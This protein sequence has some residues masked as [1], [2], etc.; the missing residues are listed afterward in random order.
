MFLSLRAHKNIL[1]SFSIKNW[2]KTFET[3]GLE[4]S[5][6]WKTINH[7]HHSLKSSLANNFEVSPLSVYGFSFS[8]FIK[9]I[10]LLCLL[11]WLWEYLRAVCAEYLTS[12]IVLI[13]MKYFPFCL[14]SLF[15]ASA[16]GLH[17]RLYFILVTRTSEVIYC[18]LSFWQLHL[19]SL[20]QTRKKRKSVLA[21]KTWKRN[22]PSDD[23]Y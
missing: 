1:S 21:L 20:D 18:R 9:K 12:Q 11:Q 5:R 4:N 22:L 14:F 13:S 16:L 10:K 19:Q 7:S 3:R 8:R 15:I 6:Q 17:K 2:S 23:L